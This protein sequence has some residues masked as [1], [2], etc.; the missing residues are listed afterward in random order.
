[1]FRDACHR[2]E[3]NAVKSEA[4]ARRR[5][6]LSGFGNV[7]Q[8]YNRS[9]YI[10]TGMVHCNAVNGL[11]QLETIRCTALGRFPRRPRAFDW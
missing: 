4:I 8:R 6:E 7:R 3:Q 10:F 5:K 1:M 2:A 11:K 9:S